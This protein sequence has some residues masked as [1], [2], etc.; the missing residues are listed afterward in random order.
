MADQNDGAGIDLEY[1][2]EDISEE[3]STRIAGAVLIIIG[4]LLGAQLG[5]LLVASN[6]D[7]ILSANLDSSEEYSDVTG[8]VISSLS[9]NDSGG[10]PV[11]GVR[12]RLLS[13]EGATTGKESFTDSDGRFKIPDVRREAVL[14]SFSHPGNNTTKFY[15]VPGDQIQII[16]T[17]TV[18]NGSR[19][20]I[21]EER[22][23]KDNQP[24]SLLQ[25]HS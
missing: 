19:L 24:P 20:L 17:M 25:L 3:S 14:L 9:G 15:F 6:P 5:I 18:G 12:V 22:A 8:I 11:E 1:F 21:C 23:I 2:L 7:D 16:I 4:S 13:E 10:D